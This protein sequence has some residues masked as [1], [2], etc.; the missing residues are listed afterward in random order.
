[1]N[2]FRDNSKKKKKYEYRGRSRGCVSPGPPCDLVDDG[3]YKNDVT[4]W[5]VFR[6]TYKR[7]LKL[8][9]QARRA[10]SAS[11]PSCTRKLVLQLALS[12]GPNGILSLSSAIL[13]PQT[14][15]G[16]SMPPCRTLAIVSLSLFHPLAP[17]LSLF[18]SLPYS[19]FSVVVAIRRASAGCA[20]E[21]AFAS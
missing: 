15:R 11:T 4:T 19:H 20:R 17:S 21:G 5:K 14:L 16:P 18:T 1:M 6:S 2:C 8:P 12:F 7:L 9:P 13:S 3:A 10:S